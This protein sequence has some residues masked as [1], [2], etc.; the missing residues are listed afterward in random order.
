MGYSK[1]RNVVL[2]GYFRGTLGVLQGTLGVAMA[3]LWAHSSG[4]LRGVRARAPAV[5]CFLGDKRRAYI[6]ANTQAFAHN[7]LAPARPPA[8]DSC[9][10]IDI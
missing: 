8:V 1:V 5:V 3:E 4:V 10:F 6:S 2:Q 7:A 9:V